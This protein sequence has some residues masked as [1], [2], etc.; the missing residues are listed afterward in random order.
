MPTYDYKC[1]RCGKVFEAF[2]TMASFKGQRCECG[3]KCE[4]FFGRGGAAAHVFKP[5]WYHDICEKSLWIE[6]KR[7]LKEECDKHGVVA[8]RLL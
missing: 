6:S 7:Q 4:V 5:M 1:Q 8:A 2:N 3:G